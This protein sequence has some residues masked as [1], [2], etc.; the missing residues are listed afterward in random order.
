MYLTA[1]PEIQ[2]KLQEEIDRVIGNSRLPV[3]SDR[4]K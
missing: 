2:T 4:V 1:H 3:L